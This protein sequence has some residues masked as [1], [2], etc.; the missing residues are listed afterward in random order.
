[1]GKQRKANAVVEMAK[2]KRVFL[3]NS[4][5]TPLHQYYLGQTPD[6]ASWEMAPKLDVPALPVSSGT[7]HKSKRRRLTEEGVAKLKPPSKEVKTETHIDALVPGLVLTV[8][9]AG[10]KAWRLIHHT[11]G[12]RQYQALGHFPIMSVAAAR[13][14][15]RAFLADP[16][17]VLRKAEAKTVT[18]VVELYLR[19]QVEGR[20]RSADQVRRIFLVYVLPSWGNR[21]FAELRRSDVVEL[22]DDIED[23]NGPAMA[24]HVFAQLRTLMGWWETRTDDYRP[25]LTRG[26]RKQQAHEQRRERILD[27]AEIRALWHVTGELPAYGGFGTMVRLLLLTAQRREK[28]VQM[29]WSDLKDGTWQISREPREKFNAGSLKLPPLALELIATL[30]KVDGNPHVFA[31]RGSKP[32]CM[33]SY[34]KADIDAGMLAY[35]RQTDPKAE[36]PNWTYH[37]IR[38]TA[39]SLLSI[40]FQP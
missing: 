1:M 10:T 26:M 13:D 7:E 16:Q 30:P 8:S 2:R 15:A 23:D 6:G 24:D 36:L 39:R 5:E 19:R 28:L 9:Y 29:R 34:R 11:N 25:P 37:D 20:L 35:L 33:W 31:G 32:T 17:A 18:Q 14:A 27:D 22:L 4:S 40:R 38:R 21:V 12:R 3:T